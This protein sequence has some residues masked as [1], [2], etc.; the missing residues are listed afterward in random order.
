VSSINVI[1]ATTSADVKAEIIA[2][3]IKARADMNLVGGHFIAADKVDSFLEST[4]SPP[5]CAV[6]LVGDP[7]ETSALAE[8]W[9]AERADLVVM[10]LDVVDD[11]VRIA[12]RD[13]RLEALLTAL[14]GLV[15]RVGTPEEVRVA[16]IQLEPVEPAQPAAIRPVEPVTEVPEAEPPTCALLNASIEWLHQLLRDAVE[17]V[18][19]ENGDVNGLSVTQA[20]LLQALD[21]PPERPDTARPANLAAAEAALDAAFAAKHKNTEPLAAAACGLNLDDLEFRMLLLGLAPEIDF[22][23]QRCIGFLLD[24]LGR[25]V[26][27]FGLYATLLG[28]STRIRR[29]LAKSG[30]LERWVVFEPSGGH[31]APAD[32]PLRVDPF[33]AQWLLG[34]GGALWGDPRVRRAIRVEPWLGAALLKRPQEAVRATQLWYELR[35][36]KGAPWL[37]LNGDDLGGWRALF[38]LAATAHG[39]APIRVEIA[40]LSSLDL[41]DVEDTAKRICRLARLTGRPLIVDT[42]NVEAAD[43]DDEWMRRFFATVGARGCRAAVICGHEARIVRLLG[44]APYELINEESLTV[45]AQIEAVETAAGTAEVY[46]TSEEAQALASRFP[47]PIDRLEQATHL[48]RNRPLDYDVHDPRLERFTTALKELVAEGIS[49]L[50]DRLEPVFDLDDVILPADRKSQLIEIVD[51]VRLAHLVLDDWKFGKQL[52][53]G[54]GVT[55]LFFGQ[56]GTG[57]TMAAMGIARRL[58]VQILRLDLSRVVSKYIGDTEKNLDR[59][60]TDAQRSGAAILI[61]EAD[62]LLGKRSEVKD[63]HDRYAN[64]EVAFL[65][66]RM[67]AY[68]GLA[69]L[70]SNMRQGIDPAF[71]RRL[72]FIIDFPRPDVE[73][74]EKI[75]RHCLPADSYTLDDAAFRQ[76][77]RKVDTTGG[78]IRQITL[79]AAFIAAAAGSLIT[80]EHIAQAARAE[81]TKLGMPAVDLDLGQGRRAA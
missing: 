81:L 65:L 5:H 77:A 76:L 4:P 59:V 58:N 28:V 40:R 39:V 22:R 78:H 10:L 64:I 49:H 55:A 31:R 61:D 14:R 52:P 15:E 71:L 37:V 11:V 45:A 48:A 60:F 63:A 79:R 23:F 7:A 35:G 72:R 70:T 6:V 13:P 53:Y 34:E 38:E 68:Q 27:T 74:R 80:L 54:R 73:A 47:L 36:A 25:R 75:W 67:E 19:V 3:S 57:K 46:V 66:Q 8:R 43:G 26:G 62:A 56:S 29:M 16:H 32:E 18:P 33:L 1:V 30:A 2:E 42:N 50:A 20:T 17:R 51:N 41:V 69:I 21:E 44:A 12:L 9:L 24:E